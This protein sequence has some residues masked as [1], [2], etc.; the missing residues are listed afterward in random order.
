MHVNPVT[1]G[2]SYKEFLKT[3]LSFPYLALLTLTIAVS[4]RGHTELVINQSGFLSVLNTGSS[5]GL[6][7]PSCEC[8]NLLS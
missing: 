7:S 2:L 4:L 3:R 6:R 1:R 8:V 5:A